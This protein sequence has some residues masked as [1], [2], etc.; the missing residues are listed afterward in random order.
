MRRHLNTGE[1]SLRSLFCEVQAD[2]RFFGLG[3]AIGMKMILDDE[4]GA[5]GN[6][7]RKSFREEMRLRT[8]SP[9][10]KR[11]GSGPGSHSTETWLRTLLRPFVNAAA[12][13]GEVKNVM[14]HRTGRGFHV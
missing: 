2:P 14:H 13:V 6:V 10:A 8:D 12:A 5:F 7:Q 9:T 11:Y 3:F 1:P 4:V